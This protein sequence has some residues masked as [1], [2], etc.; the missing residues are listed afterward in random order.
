VYVQFSNHTQLETYQTHSN[1]SQN[2]QAAFQAAQVL[3]GTGGHTSK[4][5]VRICTT[6]FPFLPCMNTQAFSD[7]DGN[8]CFGSGSAQIRNAGS[9]LIRN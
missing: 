7:A 1:A 8:Q 3:V 4:E 6:T 5:T 2:A 9:A